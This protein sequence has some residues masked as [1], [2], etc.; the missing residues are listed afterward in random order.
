MAAE[1]PAGLEESMVDTPDGA[2]LALRLLPHPDP[3]APVVLVLPAMAIKAKFY[4]PLLKAFHAAGLT[5][6]VADLRAQGDSTPKLGEGPGF[7]YRELLEVDLPAVAATLRAR[8]PQA[9]LHL[10]GHSVGGQLAL[11]YAAAEPEGVASVTTI[12][13]GSVYWRSFPAQR[14]L[15]ILATTQW[16]GLVCRVRG[17]WPGGGGIGPMTGG[18]MADWVRHARTGRYRPRGSARDYDRLLAGLALPVLAVSLDNDPLGPEPTVR[19][20]CERM[21]A[22]KL[23]RW[24][25]DGSSGLKHLGHASWVKDSDLVGPA[26]AA[27]MTSGKVPG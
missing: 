22:A 8:F 4:L 21:P 2:R 1:A 5:A 26:V 9:P 19:F 27:W 15:P 17:N 18:V 13:T 20:L 7:G 3:A 25:I 24:H 12:G 11:L 14:R 10:F 16:V 23:A 6:T